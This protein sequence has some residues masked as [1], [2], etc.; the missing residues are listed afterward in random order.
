MQPPSLPLSNTADPPLAFVRPLALGSL[1]AALVAL[2]ACLLL[3]ALLAVIQGTQGWQFLL[4]MAQAQAWP[5][6]AV[7][8]LQHPV[9][10]CLWTALACIPG[11]VSSWGL[12]RQRPW[13]PWSFAL[14]LLLS[15]LSSFALVAWI[16]QQ[17]A[18]MVAQ[19]THP[20][21]VTA[22]QAQ[23]WVAT[24]TLLGTAVMFAA[25]QAWLAWRLLQSDVRA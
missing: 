22:L 2:L 12:Y 23:R 5:P 9:A 24:L 21:V 13:G 14:V 3:A 11:A 4:Q 10:L 17:M 20:A 7:W 16:D 8:V 6:D 1:L 18:W 19:R 15:V 25:P